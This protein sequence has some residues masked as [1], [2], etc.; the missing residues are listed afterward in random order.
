MK[1]SFSISVV[2]AALSVVLAAQFLAAQTVATPLMAIKDSNERVKRVLD[3]NAGKKLDQ[4]TE[5]TLRGII[6]AATHFSTMSDAV[7]TVFPPLTTPTQRI[8]F[9]SAFES[10]LLLSSVKKMGRYKAD[11]FEYKQ[12]TVAAGGQ[13]ALVKTV[14]VYTKKDGRIDRVSLDYTMSKVG[15]KWMIV[16]YT[17]DGIDTIRNY[18]RQF[19]ILLRDKGIDGTIK[20]VENRVAEYRTDE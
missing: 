19:R 8:K 12:Q 20:H 9:K 15:G 18:Q 5:G 7:V 13:S 11:R 1:K 6:S 14:A 4:A 3:A 10:L 2:A 16:N 17:M